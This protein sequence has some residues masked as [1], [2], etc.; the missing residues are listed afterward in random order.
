MLPLVLASSSRYR[1]AMLAEAGI[2]ATVDP[3]EVDERLL[4]DSLAEL[5]AGGVALELARRKAA[6]VAPRHPGALIV[7]ADQVGVVRRPGRTRAGTDVAAGEGVGEHEAERAGDGD[8]DGDGVQLML[9]K[10]PDV[11]RSVRQLMAMSGT[12]HELVNGVVVLDTSTQR[13]AEGV[14]RQVVTMRDFTEAEARSYVAR[15]EPFDSSGSYRLE[16]Q[17]QMAPLAPFVVAVH[18]EH[19]S[20][21]LGLPMPLL[22]RLLDSLDQGAG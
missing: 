15:F 9:T 21:V 7:A 3:P 22:G 17:E 2:A 10:Q 1:A 8:G 19:D 5:G 18:G 11:E 4:D 20:G 16:D 13:S 12:S 6:V 14:D